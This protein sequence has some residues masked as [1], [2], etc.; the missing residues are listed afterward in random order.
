MRR[1]TVSVGEF[2]THCGHSWKAGVAPVDLSWKVGWK[3]SAE[4]LLH[5]FEMVVYHTEYDAVIL[6]LMKAKKTASDMLDTQPIKELLE[7]IKT[8][9]SEEAATSAKDSSTAASVAEPLPLPDDDDDPAMV[10][11]AEA[12]GI[13][14]KELDA[15]EENEARK[16]DRYK[17]QA[18]QLVAA[19]VTL[20]DECK[21]D[22]AILAL[23][24]DCPAGK[25]RGDPAPD[26]RT[27]VLIYYDQQDAGEAT[28]QPH[29]RTPPLRAKG[30]HL[31]R[32]LSL[33]IRRGN[34]DADELEDNDVFII[35]DAGR[36][37]NKTLILNAFL[38]HTGQVTGQCTVRSI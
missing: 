1:I 31:Q 12:Q 33:C 13:V 29:L 26:R 4:M 9:L 36:G 8:A 21:S 10:N 11:G 7:E 19:H 6:T 22:E 27:H 5:L 35:N 32:F 2:R 15:L 3:N 17:R 34:P 37:G 24:K 16:L 38:N 20:I 14:L 25:A 18:E 30:Q 28:A 23:L